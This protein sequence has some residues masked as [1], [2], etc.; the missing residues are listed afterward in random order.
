MMAVGNFNLTDYGV[1]A[2]CTGVSLPYG[3]VA[4]MLCKIWT[5]S[6]HNPQ[7]LLGLC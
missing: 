3:W 2:L 5:A 7:I 4:G 1:F 6:L